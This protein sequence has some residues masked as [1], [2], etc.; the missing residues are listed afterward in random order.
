MAGHRIDGL[1]CSNSSV[2]TSEGKRAEKERK[3]R[4]VFELEEGSVDWAI[5]MEIFRRSRA[6]S[7]MGRQR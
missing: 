7:P 3:N 6:G 1:T 5:M 2:S 4:V